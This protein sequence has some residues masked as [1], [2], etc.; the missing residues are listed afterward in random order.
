MKIFLKKRTCIFH[1]ELAIIS[2]C[3]TQFWQHLQP[4]LCPLLWPIW[5][6]SHFTPWVPNNNKSLFIILYN[7]QNGIS[8]V[9]HETLDFDPSDT[10]SAVIKA[11]KWTSKQSVFVGSAEFFNPESFRIQN[12]LCYCQKFYLYFCLVVGLGTLLCKMVK[13]P[14]KQMIWIP[15]NERE[16]EK[17]R[18]KGL[19]SK[20]LNGF[21]ILSSY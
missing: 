14:L 12:V 2:K 10:T 9:A 13:T 1:E 15:W 17:C 7:M 21:T 20:I 5:P 18:E 4:L 19:P 6:P 3:M 11:A 8:M 16:R